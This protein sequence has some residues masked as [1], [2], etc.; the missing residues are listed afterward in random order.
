MQMGSFVEEEIGYKIDPKEQ[1]LSVLE[2]VALLVKELL[3]DF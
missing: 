2:M 3:K 1:L